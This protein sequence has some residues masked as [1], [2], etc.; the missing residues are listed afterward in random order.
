MTAKDQADAIN[1][2]KNGEGEVLG[3]TDAPFESSKWSV[4]V[5]QPEPVPESEPTPVDG[6]SA[7]PVDHSGEVVHA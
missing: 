5:Y 2:I 7:E 1:R 6:S 4:T 3:E